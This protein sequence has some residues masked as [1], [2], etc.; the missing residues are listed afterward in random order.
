M[1]IVNHYNLFNYLQVK[2]RLKSKNVVVNVLYSEKVWANFLKELF[3]YLVFEMWLLFTIQ[4][5]ETIFSC[6]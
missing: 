6:W 2:I 4:M 5:M 1:Y 3:V